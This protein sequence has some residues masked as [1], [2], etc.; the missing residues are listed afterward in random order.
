VNRDVVDFISNYARRDYSN[1][2]RRDHM[3]D[4]IIGS[5]N[6]V[7]VHEV[8]VDEV[9]VDEVSVDHRV[10]LPRG[11]HNHASA[12]AGIRRQEIRREMRESLTLHQPIAEHRVV[13]AGLSRGMMENL[14]EEARFDR[15][16]I[17]DTNVDRNVESHNVLSFTGSGNRNQRNNAVNQRYNGNAGNQR[18]YRR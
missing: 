18:N 5:A 10:E 17:I 9:S 3:Q 15:F 16:R 2:A 7:S 8:S 12:G 14:R 6:Q 11:L 4:E 1:Y 13:E